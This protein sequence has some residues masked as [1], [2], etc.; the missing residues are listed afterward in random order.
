MTVPERIIMYFEACGYEKVSTNL[1]HEAKLYVN[2]KGCKPFSYSV[3][4][5]FK[6]TCEEMLD[7][8]TFADARTFIYTLKRHRA[9][10]LEQMGDG[11]YYSN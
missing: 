9:E 8:K 6:I 2:L 5:N 4:N 7:E 1:W 3:D 10:L 11:A